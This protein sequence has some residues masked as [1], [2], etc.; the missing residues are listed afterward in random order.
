[1]SWNTLDGRVRCVAPTGS[2]VAPDGPGHFEHMVADADVAATRHTSRIRTGP[3]PSPAG[4][5]AAADVTLI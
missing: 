1:V 3:A 4:F 2:A 5:A